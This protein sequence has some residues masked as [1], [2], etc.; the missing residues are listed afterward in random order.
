MP[1][2]SLFVLSLSP[3]ISQEWSAAC[4]EFEV[5]V[6]FLIVFVAVVCAGVAYAV[7]VW[8]KRRTPP[9]AL[10]LMLGLIVGCA[11]IKSVDWAQFMW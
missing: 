1:S 9:T 4:H 7:A 8:R 5:S 2:V 10:D 6:A 3:L 11:V